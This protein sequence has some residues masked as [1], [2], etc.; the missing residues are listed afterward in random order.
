[1]AYQSMGE[2]ITERRKAAELIEHQATFDTLT[3]LPNRRLLLDRLMQALARCRRHGHQGALLFLDLDQFK[4][5]NDSLGH[6]VGDALLQEVSR[7]LKKSLREEDTSARLGGD[8]FVV[9]FS[10]LNDNPKQAAQQA[11]A[12]AEKIQSR[13]AAP[14]TIHN[15][16]LHITASIG[17]AMFPMKDEDADDIVKYA[18]TA[19]YRAKEAGRNTIRFFLPSMQLA[20]QERL[21]LQ[22][23]LRQALLRNELQLH[24]QPQVD[25]YGNIIG[26]EALLRWQHPERG[27][28]APIC[29]IPMAEETG[30]ILTLGEWV[31]ESALYRLK[32]WTDNIAESSLRNLAINVSPRQFRQEDFALQVKRILDLTGADPHRLTLELTEGILLENLE[33]TTH[34]M[35]T[36]KRLGIR[37]S[38]D[39]F[40]TGYSSLA[41]LKRL[42][43]DE[44]KI[45]RSFVCDITTDPSDANLVETIITM[46]EHLGLEVVAEGVETE[47]QL[48]FLRGKGCRIFQGYYFSKPRSVE[49]FAKLLSE[50]ITRLAYSGTGVP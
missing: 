2:D 10:E 15:H 30:Q 1:M 46:A 39:D 25:T 13:L 44:I 35:R 6:P 17:I 21:R 5:I 38:I 8:E 33:D 45:D 11:Q 47:E 42:P 27:N 16:E 14:Y 43:L 3:D 37:F 23:D 36:L 29:F 26:A 22:N 48:E 4:H 28:I 24:F 20:A 7:R 18:D 19:M 32:A 9:L 49:D 40:G 31:L 34:K 41:Y 12:G 50:P